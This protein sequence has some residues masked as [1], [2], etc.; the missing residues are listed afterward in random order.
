MLVDSQ[1]I[2]KRNKINNAFIIH[3]TV[4][5]TEKYPHKIKTWQPIHDH[6]KPSSRFS[7]LL[8]P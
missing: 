6:A 3:I 5:S 7:I 2:G 8:D 4:K 1:G